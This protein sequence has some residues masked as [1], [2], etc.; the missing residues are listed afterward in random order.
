MLREPCE[1][2]RWP[3]MKARCLDNTCKAFIFVDAYGGNCTAYCQVAAGTDCVSVEEDVGDSRI[4]TKADE[5]AQMSC[6]IDVRKYGS[7][8]DVLCICAAPQ[9]TTWAPAVYVL[10]GGDQI[11]RG[12]GWNRDG[13]PRHDEGIFSIV[14][15]AAACSGDVECTG[16]D[17]NEENCWK[18]RHVDVTGET[19]LGARCYKNIVI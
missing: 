11:C 18:F 17:L 19:Y 15:C 4:R 1:N 3:D 10:V 16:F 2:T 6:G 14:T 8:S 13:W 5:S 9:A 12:T 7:G